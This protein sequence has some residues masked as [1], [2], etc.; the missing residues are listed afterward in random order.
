M[1]VNADADEKMNMS[2]WTDA[3]ADQISRWINISR[4]TNADANADTSVDAY[5]NA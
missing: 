2:I 5:A 4:S 1:S 3:D